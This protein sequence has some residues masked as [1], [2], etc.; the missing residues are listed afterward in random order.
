MHG[1]VRRERVS[2]RG[3]G[4]E[5]WGAMCE[6]L[7]LAPD[8]QCGLPTQFAALNTEGRGR[9]AAT[10][11]RPRPS[12]KLWIALLQ[13]SR[14]STLSLAWLRAGQLANRNFAR[15][16]RRLCVGQGR[17]RVP[18]LAQAPPCP[19][20]LAGSATR[21][22][23]RPDTLMQDRKA[24][25]STKPLATHGRTIRWVKVSRATRLF[26]TAGLPR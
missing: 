6:A 11:P 12:V 25:R 18:H 13:P 9:R 14:D 20:R 15:G 4:C 26:G 1:H 2:T 10:P 3:I 22:N 19:Q 21:S 8:A 17:L 24:A 23:Q 7:S 5:T 16:D